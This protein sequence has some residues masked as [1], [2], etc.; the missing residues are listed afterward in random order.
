DVIGD[1][2]RA[3]PCLGSDRPI[4][5]PEQRERVCIRDGKHRYLHYDIRVLP[6]DS[7]GSLNC[8]PARGKRVAGMDRHIHNRAAL[9]ALLGPVCALGVY[10]A[11]EISV[12]PGVGIDDAADRP[13]LVRHFWLDAAP[14]RSVSCDDDFAFYV[15]AEFGE[16]FIIR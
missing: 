7:L 12:V 13:M 8:A 9:H 16:L 4:Q 3:A 11:L 6:R 15:D 1:W 2:Q 5:S 10:I 14:A